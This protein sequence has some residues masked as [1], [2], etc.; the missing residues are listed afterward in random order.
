MLLK[1]DKNA[2]TK[3]RGR[4]GR[5]NRVYIVHRD[6]MRYLSAL[7]RLNTRLVGAARF[8]AAVRGI[9]PQENTKKNQITN[10]THLDNIRGRISHEK[11]CSPVGTKI[12]WIYQ[13]TAIWPTREGDG[14]RR[15]GERKSGCC[16]GEYS[17]ARTEETQRECRI[18]ISGNYHFSL[19]FIDIPTTVLSEGR[20]GEN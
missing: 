1:S 16:R 4:N 6:K 13:R 9:L 20:S 19:D 14:E 3:Y 18:H 10:L 12:P 8:L 2:N 17:E 11:L 15:M 5:R 7:L